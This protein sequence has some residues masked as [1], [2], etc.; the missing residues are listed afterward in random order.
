LDS[1][2]NGLNDRSVLVQGFACGF[3]SIVYAISGFLQ[4]AVSTGLTSDPTGTVSNDV[5]GGLVLL[6]ISV[7]FGTGVLMTGKG[8]NETRSYYLVGSFLAVIYGLTGFLITISG[9]ISSIT[10]LEEVGVNVSDFAEPSIILSL[11]VILVFLLSGIANGF[12]K[13]GMLKNDG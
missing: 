4:I 3:F 1:D 12:S 9:F 8:R 2:E 5:L 6:I 13:R 7:I 10:G 11:M